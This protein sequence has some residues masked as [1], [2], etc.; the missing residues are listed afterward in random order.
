MIVKFKEKPSAEFVEKFTIKIEGLLSSHN[1]KFSIELWDNHSGIISSYVDDVHKEDL[2]LWIKKCAIK[3]PKLKK[4]IE[5]HLFE[6][7]LDENISDDK[8]WLEAYIIQEQ[9][10]KH[11]KKDPGNPIDNDPYWHLWDKRPKN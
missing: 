2:Y 5:V 10:Y 8:I 7:G 9:L 3:M 4:E 1:M 6:Q 11:L